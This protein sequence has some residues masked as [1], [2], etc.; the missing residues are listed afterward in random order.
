MEL[1]DRQL[2]AQQFDQALQMCQYVFN[3]MAKGTDDTNQR[4]WQFPPFKEMKAENVLETLFLG[5]A[6]Q[7]DK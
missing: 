1:V 6:Q 2:K 7:P 4:V 5:L 3:P